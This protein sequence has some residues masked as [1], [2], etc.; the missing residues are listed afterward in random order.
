MLVVFGAAR[1]YSR[2]I[3]L[4]PMRNAFMVPKEMGGQISKNV[5]AR[6]S[7]AIASE[8]PTDQA[9]ECFTV[10]G[11]KISC[12]DREQAID[13]FYRFIAAKCSGMVTAID[14]HGIVESQSDSQFRNIINSARMTLPDGK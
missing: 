2:E 6:S 9:I 3:R 12:V 1:G 10:G 7:V 4:E 8:V 5:S 14:A 11:V 13:H